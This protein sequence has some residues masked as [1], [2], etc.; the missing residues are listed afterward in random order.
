MHINLYQYITELFC[1]IP[2]TNTTLYINYTS[3]ENIK[4]KSNYETI[5]V[6]L[7]SGAKF[8]DNSPCS[9]R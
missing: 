9:N 3:I 1:C 4:K 7:F 5:N 6:S 2:E 8:W